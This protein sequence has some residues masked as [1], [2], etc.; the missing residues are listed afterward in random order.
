ML[1]PRWHK[2]RNCVIYDVRLVDES[3]KKKLF[4]TGHTSRKVAKEYE[5]KKRNEIAERKLFPERYFVKRKFADFVPE[6]LKKYA[7]Q[8]KP[9]TYSDY[10]SISRKLIRFF[11]EYYL[12]EISRYH[13]ESYQSERSQQVGVCMVNREITILKGILTK[14]IDWGFLIKNPVKGVKLEK[15][16]PRLRYLNHEEISQLIES[17]GKN[18]Q[19]RYLRPMVTI[20]IHTGLRKE[21]IL[22]LK[23]ES[24][25]L[26]RNVITVQEGKGG[27]TRFVPINETAKRE[28]I[29]LINRGDSEYVFHDVRGLPFKD[30]KKSFNS[31]VARAGLKDVQFH[32]L[33][34]T[35]AT[36][37][38]FRNVPPKTLQKWMGHKKIETTMKYY[39]VSPDDF[40]QEAI[41]RLDGI[42]DSSRDTQK[43][44]QP[45]KLPKCL[46]NM[47]E[48]NGV[49]PSTS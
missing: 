2:K 27:Y 40:E 10:V 46:K 5:Q 42:T 4:V 12:H 16:S 22:K 30:I 24:V 18:G 37:C 33:R 28:L 3:G 15:E 11:N 35:F 23:K 47:V 38:V 20:D 14:A 31:A 9:G 36:W 41:K 49:E 13:I 44:R 25:D 21:E 48:L 34:K 8:K 29:G 32:D 7:S 43:N 19:V 6:Y 1:I 45:G 26:E 17:C 39:V